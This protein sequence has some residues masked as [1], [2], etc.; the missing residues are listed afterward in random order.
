MEVN[1]L[2][3]IILPLPVTNPLYSLMRRLAEYLPAI[4]LLALLDQLM[5]ERTPPWRRA[6]IAA[7]LLEL[8][9]LVN[10]AVPIALVV[11]FAV[12][13]AAFNSQRSRQCRREERDPPVPS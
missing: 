4:G 11:R 2:N 13:N 7:G 3:R 5:D 10:A 1:R 12:L 8:V 9:S 6:A